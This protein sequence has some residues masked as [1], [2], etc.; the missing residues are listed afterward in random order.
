MA[1]VV[2][3]NRCN[4]GEGGRDFCEAHDAPASKQ[5]AA[6]NTSWGA[7]QVQ[8]HVTSCLALVR[9]S[10]GH[11]IQNKVGLLLKSSCEI[12]EQETAQRAQAQ[13]DHLLCRYGRKHC[14]IVGTSLQRSIRAQTRQAGDE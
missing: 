8:L 9:A 13:H 11:L 7:A 14:P 12:T 10:E 1:I 6:T 5:E 3:R 2:A 4:H